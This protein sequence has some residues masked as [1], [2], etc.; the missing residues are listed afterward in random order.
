MARK[1]HTM[2]LRPA[3]RDN[4]SEGLRLA[5]FDVSRL[6][7]AA[8]I[9]RFLCNTP[10]WLLEEAGHFFGLRLPLYGGDKPAALTGHILANRA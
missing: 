2:P 4:A 6:A 1:G 10:G 3:T 9:D 8:E 7:T 5:L